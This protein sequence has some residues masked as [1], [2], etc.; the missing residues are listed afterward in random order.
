MEPIVVGLAQQYVEQLAVKRINAAEGDGPTIMQRYRLP[1]HPAI[2]LFDK[3]GQETQ[4]LVG[5]QSAEVIETALKQLL[6]AKN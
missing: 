4:R 6:Q 5:A 1:G 2:L 3:E